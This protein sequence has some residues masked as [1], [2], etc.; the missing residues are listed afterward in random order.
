VFYSIDKIS[1]ILYTSIKQE[2]NV[3][4][5]MTKASW[6]GIMAMEELWSKYHPVILE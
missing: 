6:T 5:K 2:K 4:V 1:K 3:A